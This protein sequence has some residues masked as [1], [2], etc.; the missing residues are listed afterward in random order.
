MIN[1]EKLVEQLHKSSP[2]TRDS[3]LDDLRRAD[4]Q[5]VLELL[6]DWKLWARPNQIVPQTDIYGN[7]WPKN[8]RWRNWLLLSG[9]GFGKTRT[10]AETIRGWAESGD[11]K[12]MAIVGATAAAVRDVMVEG[13]GGL[14]SCCPPWNEPKY[15]ESRNRIIWDNPN[16][17]SYKCVIQTYS[18]EEPERLRGPQHEK[19]WC[20][21]L[22]AWKYPKD[23]YDMAMLGLRLGR[24]PQNIITTTPKPLELLVGTSENRRLGLLHQET[25]A[26]TIGTT[27]D[28]VDNL[29]ADFF[30]DIVTKYEGTRLG[31]QEL[32]AAILEDVPGALWHRENIERHRVAT[33]PCSKACPPDCDKHMSRLPTMLKIVVAIDPAGATTTSAG[34]TGL[35]VSGYGDNGDFYMFY[36]NSFKVHPDQWA[37][38]A[39]NLFD[40]FQADEIVCE[41]NYGGEMVENTIR[42]IRPH[43]PIVQV[44][45]S[46]GKV[47]RAEPIA[48]LYERGR[49]HHVGTWAAGEDQMCT[50]NPLENKE[51]LKDMV[52]A[53][54]WGMSRLVEFSE[55]SALH[56]RPR[57][58]GERTLLT[59][60]N[61]VYSR[62]A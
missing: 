12:R 52:D 15:Q 29:A 44:R 14:K 56:N 46:R 55:P 8:K 54:V 30:N 27:Y 62:F 17:P 26:L 42:Q 10:G 19:L 18:A 6:Y 2:E 50:F 61:D 28:N 58:L 3:I 32:L 39:V 47:A 38:M 60:Y 57:A 4:N 36:L 37:Q 16:Y 7:P 51:G 40:E 34:E 23:A 48:L 33:K 43:A 53:L 25:T 45:A 1:I 13:P 11:F 22:L 21:E 35:N 9:R 24:S 20:D 41:T 5:Q 31:R 59:R 49:V